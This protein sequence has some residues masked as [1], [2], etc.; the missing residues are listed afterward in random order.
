MVAAHHF[1]SGSVIIAAALLAG[2]V[3]RLVL[4]EREAGMLA[5][6]GRGWDA[7]TLGSLGVLIAIAALIV[8]A[9]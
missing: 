5:V 3:L 8:P 7:F 6:R 4:S 1:Q 9:S 2:A